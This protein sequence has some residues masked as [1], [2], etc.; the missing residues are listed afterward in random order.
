MADL[1]KLYKLKS[2]K[3]VGGSCIVGLGILGILKTLGYP[4]DVWNLFWPTVLILIGTGMLLEPREYRHSV[5]GFVCVLIGGSFLI[6]NLGIFQF[7]VELVFYV[8]AVIVG[9]RVITV[10]SASSN[11]S[12]INTHYINVHAYFRGGKFIFP[13]CLFK[14]GVASAFFL[15]GRRID[16]CKAEIDSSHDPV[17]VNVNVMWGGLAFRVPDDWNVVMKLVN[18]GGVF[19]NKT[20]QIY[21]TEEA[22]INPVESRTLIIKGYILCGFL[23][24][25]N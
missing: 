17:I 9:I 13:R 15:G 4:V 22:L 16:L 8:T 23:I 19:F 25:T 3:V 11:K 1:N 2:P 6:R 5:N 12:I 20:K 14:G 21:Q 24:V 18:I 7:D 10:A